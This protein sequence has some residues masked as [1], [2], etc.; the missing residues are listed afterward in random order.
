MLSVR[1]LHAL[2]MLSPRFHQ[3]LC[4]VSVRSGPVYMMNQYREHGE[5]VE[6]IVTPIMSQDPSTTPSIF[7]DIA[8]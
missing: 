1:F 2:S 7:I 3:C 6:K 4:T 8:S 5:S